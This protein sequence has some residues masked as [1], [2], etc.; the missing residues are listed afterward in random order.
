M[1]H[2]T[3][4]YVPP[5]LQEQL[6]VQKRVAFKET[7]PSF[8]DPAPG[9]VVGMLAVITFTRSSARS[10][11]ARLPAIDVACALFTQRLQQDFQ[12]PLSP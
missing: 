8:Y 9:G 11:V 10:A 2:G 6:Y 1:Q 12:W 3:I 5:H 4:K 7:F